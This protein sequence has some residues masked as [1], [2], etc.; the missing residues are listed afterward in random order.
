MRGSI[1]RGFLCLNL[2]GVQPGMCSAPKR[3]K[4]GR[5]AG[6]GK[7]LLEEVNQ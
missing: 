2:Q 7:V 5:G 1:P 4:Q 6:P 3:S